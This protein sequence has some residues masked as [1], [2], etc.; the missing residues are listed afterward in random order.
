MQAEPFLGHLGGE[1]A[2]KGVEKPGLPQEGTARAADRRLL[3]IR[4][5]GAGQLNCQKHRS[6]QQLCHLT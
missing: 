3:W 4:K 2:A 1:G 5:R 6:E